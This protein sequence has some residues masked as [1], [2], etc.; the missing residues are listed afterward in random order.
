MGLERRKRVDLV[1][2]AAAALPFVN[3]VHVGRTDLTAKDVELQARMVRPIAELQQQGRYTH[4]EHVTDAELRRLYAAADVVVHLSEAEGFGLPPLEAM[5][6][7]AR[8]IASDIAPLREVLGRHAR[9]VPLDA[10]ALWHELDALWDGAAVRDDR[11]A[12]RQERLEHARTFTWE[13]TAQLTLAAY[14]EAL[15]D[16]V[17]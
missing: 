2:E 15:R 13:R 5:A 9:F 8:V 11:P 16:R 4:I 10:K 7:G 6:C 12:N 1:A 17:G 14:K 3:L